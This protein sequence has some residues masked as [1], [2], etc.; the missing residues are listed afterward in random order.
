MK[1]ICLAGLPKMG[2]QNLRRVRRMS[3]DKQEGSS[4]CH[5]IHRMEEES[6]HSLEESYV[7]PSWIIRY[8]CVGKGEAMAKAAQLYKGRLLK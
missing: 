8:Q 3:T 7:C 2:S 1:A 5:S 4:R 6:S